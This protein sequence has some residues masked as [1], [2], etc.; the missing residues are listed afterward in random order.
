MLNITDPEFLVPLLLPLLWWQQGKRRRAA[1][2]MA[3]WTVATL[4]LLRLAETADET[5]GGSLTTTGGSSG[6]YGPGYFGSLNHGWKYRG[7]GYSS[8]GEDSSSLCFLVSGPQSLLALGELYSCRFR[9]L[10]KKFLRLP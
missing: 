8:G 10:I 3:S 2:T 6:S 9:C 4:L 1:L 5:T 7:S